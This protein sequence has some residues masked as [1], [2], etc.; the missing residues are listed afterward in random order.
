MCSKCHPSMG[1]GSLQGGTLLGLV[2][3]LRDEG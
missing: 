2:S 3:K 1:G